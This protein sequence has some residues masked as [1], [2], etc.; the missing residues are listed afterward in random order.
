MLTVLG[1]H[2]FINDIKLALWH[3]TIFLLA[4]LIP[5][6]AGAIAGQSAPDP[7][8]TDSFRLL[9]SSVIFV[10]MLSI[11]TLAFGVDSRSLESKDRAFPLRLGLGLLA[12]GQGI[13]LIGSAIPNLQVAPGLVLSSLALAFLAVLATRRLA[14]KLLALGSAPRRVLIVGTGKSAA[15]I[16]EVLTRSQARYDCVG[17]YQSEPAP[18]QLGNSHGRIFDASKPLC[19]VVSDQ[20]V[21]EIVVALD[22][23]RGALPISALLSVKLKGVEVTDLVSFYE[24]ECFTIKFDK[25]HPSWII[26]SNDF[27]LGRARRQAKR[28][29]DLL[30]SVT[31]LVLTAPLMLFV[32]VASL[33]E[34]RGRYPVF[35]NQERVGC[36]GRPFQLHKFRSMVPNAEAD[37]RARWAG[38]EDDRVTPLGKILRRYRID[39]LPQLFDILKGDMSLV[40]PRPERPEFVNALAREIPYYNERHCVPP[41]LTGWAQLM[42]PY[43]AS[44]EDAKR[45]LEYDLYYVK[46][47]SVVRDFFILLRTVEV[48]VSGQ[49]VR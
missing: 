44:I 6:V 11:S 34:S 41:G 28:L 5:V 40:G 33:V 24:R 9:A 31:M 3:A 42:Y 38:A 10:A 4:F 23:R 37:G 36:G 22:D 17:A 16:Q 39:E 18:P 49:G 13:H 27:R 47:T 26:F 35:Y 1:H 7:Y 12:G 15:D 8:I 32:C 30:A 25:L 29:F 19:D 21:Q 20:N 45:K 43:G 48:V 46:H 14:A 2:I